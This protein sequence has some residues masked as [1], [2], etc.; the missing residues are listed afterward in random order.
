MCVDIPGNTII[1]VMQDKQKVTLYLSPEV[2]RRL[3]VRAA[4]DS[5]S[6]STIAERA[7]T[8]Y[9]AHPDVVAETEEVSY[10]HTHQVYACPTCTTSL[11][12]RDGEMVT[13]NSQVGAKLG[14]IADAENELA[15]EASKNRLKIEAV[16][17]EV[18]AEEELVPC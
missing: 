13:L 1:V 14:L 4:I 8:F 18:S 17:Y 5:E 7:V 11:L 9:L 15:V 16:G 12:L 3:K 6:M 10:G 2:Y